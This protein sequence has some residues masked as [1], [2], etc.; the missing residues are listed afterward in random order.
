MT[1]LEVALIVKMRT[2]LLFIL[3]SE[4]YKNRMLMW[5]GF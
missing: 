5:K 1:S 4:N 3:E 2:E